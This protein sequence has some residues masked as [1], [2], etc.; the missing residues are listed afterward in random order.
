[1]LATFTPPPVALCLE[2]FTKIIL[3][4]K[5]DISDQLYESVIRCLLLEYHGIHESNSYSVDQIDARRLAFKVENHP[6]FS[7]AMRRWSLLLDARFADTVTSP[8]QIKMD[9]HAVTITFID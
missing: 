8:V 9:R 3:E 7:R 4:L 1:M 6:D 5:S 2:R